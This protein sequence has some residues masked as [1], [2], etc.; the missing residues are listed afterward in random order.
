MAEKTITWYSK[1]KEDIN[2]QIKQNGRREI[3]GAKLNSV[4]NKMVDA[5]GKNMTFGGVVSPATV[6]D[7]TDDNPVFYLALEA[8]NYPYCGNIVVDQGQIAF[9]FRDANNIW[10][11]ASWNAPDENFTTEEKT[12]LQGLPT[13]EELREALGAKANAPESK[14]GSD[15]LASFDEDGNLKDSGV[16]IPVPT[17]EEKE[18]VLSSGETGLEW[19]PKPA[20][21][22]DAYGVYVK[23]YKE[24]HGG[25][26][27][28]ML[29]RP[30]WLASLKGDKGDTGHNPNLGSYRLVDGDITPE[31][32]QPTKIGDYIVVID[33]GKAFKYIWDDSL[34]DWV[35]SEVEAGSQFSTGEY[36]EQVGI[37]NEPTEKS[38]NLVKSS[39]VAEIYGVYYEENPEYMRVV[40]D[41]DLNI[42][43]GVKKDGTVFAKKR[44]EAPNLNM[45]EKVDKE[46]G[47]SLIDED[48]AD[49][50]E[51]V[52]NPEWLFVELDENN[53][54]IRGIKKDGSIYEVGKKE[55]KLSL[56][57]KLEEGVIG[58]TGIES[59]RYSEFS[60]GKRSAYY[61]NLD[62][63]KN[64]SF[65]QNCK[66][67]K[68]GDSHSY[69]GFINA[70]ANSN[71]SVS[72]CKYI[73]IGC[74]NTVNR[75]SVHYSDSYD[76]HEEKRVQMNQDFDRVT[77]RVDSNIFTSSLLMLPPN[78]TATGKKVPL[79]L[80]D[81]GDGNYINWNE[82][83]IGGNKNGPKT[84]LEYLRDSGF[85]VLE[86][87]SWGSFYYQ[88]NNEYYYGCGNRGAMP[89]PTH[90]KT[91]NAGVQYICDRYN[92]DIENVFH[93][94]KSGSGKLALY[95]ALEKPEFGLKSIYAF[96][97]VFDDLNFGRWGFSGY[98]R[99]LYAELNP[100][101]TQDQLE[102]FLNGYDDTDTAN[103]N[104]H[105]WYF[106]NRIMYGP[107]NTGED[108]I[109]EDVASHLFEINQ[110]FIRKN[111]SKFTTVCVSWMNLVG[112]TPE[113]KFQDTLDWG[114]KFHVT[115][116]GNWENHESPDSQGNYPIYNT[117]TD[118]YN[119]HDLT[120]ISN[121]HIPI[122]VLMA[123][124]DQQTP[125]W[126]ALEVVNQL[127]NG[128]TDA[129]IVPLK[130]GSHSGHTAPDWHTNGDNAEE[131]VT[132]ILGIHYDGVPIGFYYACQDIQKRFL[133]INE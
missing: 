104:H 79:I 119:K 21:G 123:K 46:E 67:Y 122:T 105:G 124:D 71:V 80:W 16:S 7:N 49:M 22:D 40:T 63:C 126:S 65:D 31:P 133:Y 130:M 52:D 81:N 32:P 77:F 45:D 72:N 96:A 86:I 8:G 92:I 82:Y 59:Y 94:S 61:I 12:K 128:G 60:S 53:N 110:D 4:L 37:D 115:D 29:T 129:T 54:I 132:T 15:N 64:I 6:I 93:L 88:G 95:Y 19:V 14:P 58:N 38:D 66:V 33:D 125:Y 101:G 98:R 108:M 107:H 36:I 118:I 100:E 27:D 112:Q 10:N 120:M 50:V 42:I 91:H 127:R 26:T 102:Q 3:T 44:I 113:E 116:N 43:A 131:N 55:S 41:E 83:N 35:N 1:L 68:Y 57:I 5:L 109:P 78:Y 39:G 89:I 20:D 87:Y 62:G 103:I 47:K 121:S 90:I 99:A 97:P 73:R 23:E 70:I 106:N 2:G 25:S 11:Q 28:G 9:L 84:G 69:T 111:I 30:Q 74:E 114:Y 18:H 51:C 76:V 117:N 56:N 17:E 48:Y 24:E 34:S 13:V 75:I 85:A